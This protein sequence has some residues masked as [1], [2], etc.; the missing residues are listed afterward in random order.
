MQCIYLLDEW[1]CLQSA[2]QLSYP[3][4]SLLFLLCF[5]FSSRHASF[6]TCTW[7]AVFFFS[8]FSI[9][10]INIFSF[11]QSWLVANVFRFVGE[12]WMFIWMP[13]MF[14]CL[15]VNV[16]FFRFIFPLVY[17][18]CHS[19]FSTP[20]LCTV[21]LAAAHWVL[22]R[23]KLLCIYSIIHSCEYS[24]IYISTLIDL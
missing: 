8:L 24:C 9:A 18:D 4:F 22:P 2:A 10:W 7:F 20:C 6:F 17:C 19:F 13:F 12:N 21:S 23:H 3:W 15:R 5:S 1:S 16:W 11:C 14:M